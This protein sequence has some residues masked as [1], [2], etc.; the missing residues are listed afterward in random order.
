M[1]ENGHGAEKN[2]GKALEGYLK[3]S[4]GGIAEA[5]FSIGDVY[6]NGKGMLK[7]Q[8]QALGWYG[9]ARGAGLVEASARIK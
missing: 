3:G 2:S 7:D 9:K 6:R 5:M 4:D 1:Y 8:S